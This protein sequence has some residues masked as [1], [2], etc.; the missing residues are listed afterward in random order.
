MKSSCANSL[1]FSS[2]FVPS[3]SFKRARVVLVTMAD[4]FRE[5]D[6]AS[7]DDGEVNAVGALVLR[8]NRCILC[9]SLTGEWPGMRIP[10]WSAEPGEDGPTTAWKAISELCEIEDGQAKLVAGLPPVN[11]YEIGSNRIWPVPIFA[12]YAAN[13]PPAGGNPDEEDPEDNYDWYTFP[14]AM[15]ALSEDQYARAALVQIAISLRAAVSAGAVPD[16]WGGVF[17]QEWAADA[18]AQA[19]GAGGA[20]GLTMDKSSDAGLTFALPEK[21]AG[22]S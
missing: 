11:T 16:Q 18:F 22:S 2:N 15:A 13:P 10:S 14:R 8:G 4:P 12:F 9:R 7:D 21:Y 19:P 5:L 1:K 20:T 3:L 17:G 6:A